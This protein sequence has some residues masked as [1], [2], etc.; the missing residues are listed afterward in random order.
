M[1][2]EPVYIGENAVITNSVVGPHVSVGANSNV[3]DSRVSNSI[4]QSAATVRHANVTNSM[5]GN[6]ASLTGRPN[7]LSVGD[8]NALQV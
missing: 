1:L 3:R 2:I 8:F 7:D 6:S 5:I 4:I